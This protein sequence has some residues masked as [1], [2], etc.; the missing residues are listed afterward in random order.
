MKKLG[1]IVVCAWFMLA[2]AE[3]FVVKKKKKELAV[4]V[5]QD[6]GLQLE[7]TLTKLGSL[8]KKTVNVQNEIYEK[9]KDLLGESDEKSC[10]DC[11]TG[12]L[13]KIRSA[14]QE[15]DASVNLLSRKLGAFS[16]C[17]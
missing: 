13:K 6:I 16:D 7:Q 17:F 5:K 4:S 10:F 2:Q 9:V 8:I 3:S 1:F 15:F 12:E 14:L 11:S